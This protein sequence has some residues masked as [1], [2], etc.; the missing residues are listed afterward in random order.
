MA[1]RSLLYATTVSLFA[2][3]ASV[4]CLSPLGL[5][6]ESPPRAGAEQLSPREAEN[7]DD[8]PRYAGGSGATDQGETF[9]V[10]SLSLVLL[11]T[12]KPHP[13][14]ACRSPSLAMIKT[15]AAWRGTRTQR[16]P[17]ASSDEEAAGGS[18]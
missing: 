18:E 5:E 15:C 2:A 6:G 17:P 7:T 1:H 11:S 13:V 12:N 10:H 4:M 8:E 16:Q 9:R 3:A 14:P